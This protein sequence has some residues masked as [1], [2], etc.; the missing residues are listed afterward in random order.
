MV[1]EDNP[2]YC[3][4]AVA[5]E[6]D[7]RCGLTYQE[8]KDFL[9]YVNRYFN[10]TNETEADLYNLARSGKVVFYPQ[11]PLLKNLEYDEVQ[12]KA[13]ESFKGTQLMSDEKEYVAQRTVGRWNSLSLSFLPTLLFSH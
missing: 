13:I 1:D 3:P 5:R 9:L 11:L 2:L 4:E 7:W 12:L 10:P 8:Y 6:G